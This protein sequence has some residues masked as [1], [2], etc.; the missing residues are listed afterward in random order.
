LSVKIFWKLEES[1]K[2]QDNAYLKTHLN[3][4]KIKKILSIRSLSS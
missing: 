3:F 2:Q 1:E 4:L